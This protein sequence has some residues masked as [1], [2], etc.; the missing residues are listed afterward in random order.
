MALTWMKTLRLGVAMRRELLF[1]R[2]DDV[3]FF[4]NNIGYIFIVQRLEKQSNHILSRSDSISNLEPNLKIH[5]P[6]GPNAHAGADLQAFLIFCF[7][8]ILLSAHKLTL[9]IY[10]DNIRTIIF[11]KKYVR[12]LYMSFYSYRVVFCAPIPTGPRTPDF[13]SCSMSYSL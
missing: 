10:G 1:A 7:K 12:V 2:H 9:L 4:T 8:P 13:G 3:L 5:G 6:C 11:S